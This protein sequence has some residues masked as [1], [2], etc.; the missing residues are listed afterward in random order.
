M[1]VKYKGKL[2]RAV[3]STATQWANNFVSKLDTN[4]VDIRKKIVEDENGAY[5]DVLNA[6]SRSGDFSSGTEILHKLQ[7][8]AGQTWA[9]KDFKIKS[10]ETRQQ[11]YTANVKFVVELTP[12]AEAYLT[13]GK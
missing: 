4:F 7:R 11:G 6:T 12:Q 1:Y 5:I 9:I 3:D 2:Y 13:R 10:A 8:Y